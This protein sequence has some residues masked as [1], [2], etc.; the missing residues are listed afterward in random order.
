MPRHDDR[1][2]NIFSDDEVV[3]FM[4]YDECEKKDRGQ[5]RR[6]GCFS[7]VSILLLPVVSIIHFYL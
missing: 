6:G 1:N 3:D 2:D 7:V 4:I 5:R